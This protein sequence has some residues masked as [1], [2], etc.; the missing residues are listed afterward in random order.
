MPCIHIRSTWLFP[1]L[2]GITGLVLLF[3]LNACGGGTTP[4]NSSTN[5]PSP[6]A[7]SGQGGSSQTCPVKDTLHSGT[8]T[9]VEITLPPGCVV[10]FV[11]TKIGHYKA[12]FH[13]ATW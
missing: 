2:I 13:P 6:T 1:F 4:S 3:S 5:S 8:F 7:T 9:N 11:V 10:N 12:G